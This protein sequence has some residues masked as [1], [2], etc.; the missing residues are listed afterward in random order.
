[1]RWTLLS[2]RW[3]VVTLLMLGLVLM[4]HVPGHGPHEPASTAA[5][6]AAAAFDPAVSESHPL[7]CPCPATDHQVP[8][9]GGG[10]GLDLSG[11]LHLCLAILAGLGGLLAAGLMLRWVI[12]RMRLTTFPGRIAAFEYLRPPNPLPR[13]LAALGVLRL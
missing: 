10:G 7:D 3:G 13:H 5:A 11:L 1:M 12:P 9:P 8:L 6:T 2:W 4:H